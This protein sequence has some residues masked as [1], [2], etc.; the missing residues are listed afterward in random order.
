MRGILAGLLFLSATQEKKETPEY[1]AKAHFLRNFASLTKWPTGSF[2][3]KT[4][5]FKIGIL[6]T[7]PF[8]KDISKIEGMLVHDRPIAIRRSLRADDLKNCQI[9]FVASS[10]KN[11]LVRILEAFRGTSVMTVGD[12]TG[13]GESGTAFN[14]YPYGRKI[15]FEVNLKALKRAKLDVDAQVLELGKK[16]EEKE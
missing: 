3:D 10:E 13:F 15:R 11:N 8:G 7:D 1:E 14:F 6:G 2:P 4:S 5:P 12:T 16:V 9:V